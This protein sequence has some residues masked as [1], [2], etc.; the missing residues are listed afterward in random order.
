MTDTTRGHLTTDRQAAGSVH[1]NPTGD[2]VG[3]NGL[4]RYALGSVKKPVHNSA[5]ACLLTC[6]RRAI[7]GHT[8][9]GRAR[10]GGI[11]R[12]NRTRGRRIETALAAAT[13]NA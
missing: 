2:G 3:P 9:C 11:R 5:L 13:G 4:W 10:G 6:N 12:S 1:F 7:A 8:R